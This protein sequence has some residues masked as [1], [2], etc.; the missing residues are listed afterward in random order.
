MSINNWAS[1]GS[2]HFTTILVSLITMDAILG[3]TRLVHN[4]T[5]LHTS[6]NAGAQNCNNGPGT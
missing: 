6:C 2:K 3:S 1:S 5:F 4:L